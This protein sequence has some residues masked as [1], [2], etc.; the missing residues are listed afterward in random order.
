MIL[1]EIK[2]TEALQPYMKKCKCGHTLTIT[3]KYGRKICKWCGRMIYLD[4]NR[5]K[6]HDEELQKHNF[7]SKIRSILY[8]NN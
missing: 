4:D 6:E 5:Q 2:K 3:N 7:K 1:E 8:E